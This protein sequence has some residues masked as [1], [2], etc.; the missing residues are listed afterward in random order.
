MKDSSRTFFSS[1]ENCSWL[2]PISFCLSVL[3][4]LTVVTSLELKLVVVSGKVVVVVGLAVVVV[5]L[6]VVVV[7]L[8]V[9]D[10][11]GHSGLSRHSLISV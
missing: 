6:V 4:S 5:V 3:D 9:V 10:V 2:S 8:V 1:L 11:V 7:D